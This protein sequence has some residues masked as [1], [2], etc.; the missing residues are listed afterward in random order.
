M[1]PAVRLYA[2]APGRAPEVPHGRR[3]ICACVRC[4]VRRYSDARR[5]PLCRDC[6]YVLPDHERQNWTEAC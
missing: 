2:T 3:Q 1:S 6:L 4:G 5:G